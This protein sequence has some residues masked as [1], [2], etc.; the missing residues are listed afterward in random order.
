MK[1]LEF[2]AGAHTYSVGKLSALKQFHISRR[3]TPL[4]GA[5]ASVFAEAKG[6]GKSL[7]KQLDEGKKDELDLSEKEIASAL[8]A[9]GTA[10]A[11]LPDET[12][13][14]IMRECFS[15]VQR[16]Q[17]RGTG[18]ADILT[19]SGDLMYEDMDMVEMLA[20]CFHVLRHNMASFT[21]ALPSD[22]MQKAR[23]LLA[24]G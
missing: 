16:K 22:L 8:T 5:F 19:A 24:N 3:L 7:A 10:F 20:V 17:A 12:F 23:T 4:L 1:R 6:K 18:W 9:F 2:T 13:D 14:Y 15:V 21:D 11:T